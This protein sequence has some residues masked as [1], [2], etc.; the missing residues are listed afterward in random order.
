MPAPRIKEIDAELASI[1][2][3]INE[4][5]AVGFPW[6]HAVEALQY[7]G[8]LVNKRSRLERDRETLTQEAT[9]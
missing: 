8:D 4:Y 2:T 5:N 6:L 7:Y 3:E 1:N 9:G